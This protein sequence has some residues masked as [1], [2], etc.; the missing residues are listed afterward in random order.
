MNIE[1]F[2]SNKLCDLGNSDLAI[3]LKRQFLNPVELHTK[4]AQ[5]SYDITLPATT[6][7]N[8]IFGYKNV[9][10]VGDKFRIYDNVKLYVGGVL[11]LDGKFMLS[12]ITRNGY[13]G[14]L[15]VPVRKTAKDIFGHTV[16]SEAGEWLINDFKGFESMSYY[17]QKENAEC[18]FPLVLYGLLPKE[19]QGRGEYSDKDLIDSS[20]RLGLDDFP[21]S[22]N[23]IE[24]LK[25]IFNNQGYNLT[26]T[27]LVDE[28]LNNLYVSYKNPSDYQLNW[29]SHGIRLKGS[30]KHYDDTRFSPFES[31][32]TTNSD[33][34]QF[35]LNIFNSTN[36]NYEILENLGGN[37]SEVSRARSRGITLNIPYSGLYKVELNSNANIG[38]TVKINDR[39][40]GVTG[41]NLNTAPMEIHLVR[42]LDKMLDEIDFNNKFAYENIDQNLDRIN[43]KFPKPH[44]VNFIDP[45]QDSNLL[46]GFAFGKHGSNDYRN[47]MNDDFC[48]PIA[49]KGGL[50]W[51]FQDG[52]GTSYRAYSAVESPS[53]V[54]VNGDETRDFQVELENTNTHTQRHSDKN[55]SG[56]VKQ[57]VW[58]EKGDRLDL[59]L[60]TTYR[61]MNIS[62][63]GIS[64][65]SIDYDIKLTPFQHEIE[66]LTMNDDG[67]SREPMYWNDEPSFIE[68]QIDLMKALPSEIKINDWIENFCKAF[69]LDLHNTGDGFSLDLKDR[70]TVRNTSK[71]IDLDNKAS[72]QHASNLP[73]NSPYSYELGFTVD[74]DEEGYYSTQDNGGGTFIAD[75]EAS[76]TITQ[77]SSFSYNWFKT[78]REDKGGD[79]T[80][81]LPVIT[82]KEIWMNDYDYKE[83]MNKT[84]FDK[85]QRFWYKAG[86]RELNTNDNEKMINALV[87]NEYNGAK[88]QRLDYRDKPNSIMRNFFILLRNDKNYTVVQCYLTPEEYSN[89]DISLARFNGDMYNIAE[90]DGY[91][92]SGRRPATLKLI[93]KIL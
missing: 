51:D 79:E 66:W 90:I 74:A 14:N 27:A 15:G 54:L 18:I 41:G 24:M 60:S 20:V 35:N 83:M 89:L 16:M 76:N 30:W 56:E 50:S 58:L 64:D 46:C 37:I 33:K 72:V 28:R 44:K 11:I 6:T 5:K 92:P 61:E 42:N 43:A 2:I 1:L 23:C 80:I 13:K 82:D 57:V 70:G 68:G 38:D 17:N 39:R 36:H 48:N 10:E 84:Y 32:Y 86:T 4:D 75:S 78:I 69:N 12:E 21:P 40:I 19:E 93:R 52:E 7:N 62:Y 88:R 47:P 26:G 77:T 63:R 8:E 31:W 65:Y 22:V 9:E 55:A 59:L 67:S 3:T 85:V 49:I 29:G 45:K 71:I 73:L 91:D 53:Y 25:R 81:D 87:S 34:Y